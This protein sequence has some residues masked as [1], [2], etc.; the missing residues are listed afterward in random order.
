M[1]YLDDFAGVPIE[2]LVRVSN[3]WDDTDARTLGNFLRTVR[4][5]AD[6]NDHRPQALLEHF[7]DGWVVYGD[8]G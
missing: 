1:Q 4:P 3:E 5:F 7:I 2:D 6:S 8:K